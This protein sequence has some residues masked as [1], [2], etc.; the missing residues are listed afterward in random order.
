MKTALKVSESLR[1]ARQ[2]GWSMTGN[3]SFIALENAKGEFVD[4][5][6]TPLGVLRST[7]DVALGDL[8]CSVLTLIALWLDVAI[9]T[10]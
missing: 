8:P 6:S 9:P 2:A 3:G 10:L 7:G 1:T 5:W 4:V